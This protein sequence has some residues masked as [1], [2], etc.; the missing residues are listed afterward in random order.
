MK[1][2]TGYAAALA[3]AGAAVMERWFPEAWPEAPWA[4]GEVRNVVGDLVGERRAV[5]G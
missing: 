5:W 2:H 1:G 3:V 4:W